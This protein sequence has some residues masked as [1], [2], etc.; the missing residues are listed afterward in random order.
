MQNSAQNSKAKIKGA[1][2]KIRA[3]FQGAGEDDRI[4][5]RLVPIRPALP[6]LEQL[7][8]GQEL[9]LLMDEQGYVMEIA[10]RTCSRP[11][12]TQRRRGGT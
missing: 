8:E 12:D 2:A 9:V 3:V 6:K 7:K 4:K 10:T 5:I 11:A 1:H